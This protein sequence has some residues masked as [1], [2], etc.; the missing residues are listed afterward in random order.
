M[1]VRLIRPQSTFSPP[2]PPRPPLS[3]IDLNRRVY[4]YVGS[5]IS[6]FVA[7]G[8]A[9]VLMYRQQSADRD[10]VLALPRVAGNPIVY[11]DLTDG[12]VPLGRLRMHVCAHAVPLAAD[13]FTALATGRAGFGYRSSALFAVEKHTCVYGGDF[14]S[15]GGAGASVYGADFKD[16][17]LVNLKHIGPG[18]VSMRNRGPRDSNNSQFIITLA[19]TPHFDGVYQVVAYVCDEEGMALLQALDKLSTSSSVRWMKG[20]DVRIAACGVE[21]VVPPH[22]S[23]AP[24]AEVRSIV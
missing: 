20:H 24:A 15:T 9:V 2:P 19:R 1:P 13:N 5:A 11:F 12:D 4:L 8:C 22:G 3:S 10:A 21:S 6:A 23:D 7:T 18:T 14:I 17:D 16:E